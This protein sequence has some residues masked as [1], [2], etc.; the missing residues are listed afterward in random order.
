M[1]PRNDNVELPEH[2]NDCPIFLS[3]IFLSKTFCA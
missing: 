2:E 1:K 3:A